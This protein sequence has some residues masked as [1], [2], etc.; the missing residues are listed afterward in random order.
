[1]SQ[2]ISFAMLKWCHIV[3]IM[4]WKIRDNVPMMIYAILLAFIVWVSSEFYSFKISGGAPKIDVATNA[5]PI[6]AVNIEYFLHR[7]PIPFEAVGNGLRFPISRF[8]KTFT[9]QRNPIKWQMVRRPHSE[10][11]VVL[12]WTV[13]IAVRSLFYL[14]REYTRIYKHNKIF[15][16][17]SHFVSTGSVMNI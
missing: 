8:C 1:M 4:N 15:Y 7:I 9:E 5:Y 17:W 10:T 11:L 13:R 12:K 14:N 6:L 2:Q 3:I 16:V